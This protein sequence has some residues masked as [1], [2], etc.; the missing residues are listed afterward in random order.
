MKK[1]IFIFIF[2]FIMVDY[3][4]TTVNYRK[5]SEECNEMLKQC[6]SLHSDA[7]W[8]LDSLHTRTKVLEKECDSLFKELRECQN[9]NDH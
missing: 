6:D 5:R 1:L 3:S 7:M 9:Q 8:Y 2:M 4:C